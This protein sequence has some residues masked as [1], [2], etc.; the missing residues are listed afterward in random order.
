MAL[1]LKVIALML[2]AIALRLE[3]PHK[4]H[5]VGAAAENGLNAKVFKKKIEH[6]KMKQ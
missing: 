6:F 5:V 3:L 4:E 2:K 1:R